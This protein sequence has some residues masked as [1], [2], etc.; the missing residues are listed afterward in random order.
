MKTGL[1]KTQGTG[2]LEAGKKNAVQL[3]I[4]FLISFLETIDCSCTSLTLYPTLSW[5]KCNSYSEY[6]PIFLNLTDKTA[7]YTVE[8]PLLQSFISCPNLP[9][10]QIKRCPPPPQSIILSL[11]LPVFSNQIVISLG[12]SKKSRFHCISS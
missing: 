8:Y 9:T 11:K 7:L 10:T 4:I 1:S 5:M 3:E 6:S 12:H 2:L